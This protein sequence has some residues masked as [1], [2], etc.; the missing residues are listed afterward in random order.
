L[1]YPRIEINIRRLEYNSLHL[2]REM[3]KWGVTVMGVNKVFNGD[4]ECAM[5]MVRGGIKCIAESRVNNLI[6]IR[7]LPCE[8][9]LLRPPALSEI[10]DVVKYA[11]ISLVSDIEVIRALSREAVRQNKVHKIQFTID[12][13][14]IREG[15]WFQERD[16]IDT[17]IKEILKTPNIELHS[18]GTNYNCFGTVM[19]TID[20]G[21][22]LVQIGREIEKK[23]N[24]TIPYFSNGNSTSV[25]LMEKGQWPQGANHLRMG[26]LQ[27]FGLDYVDPY[28]LPGYY[29]S[30]MDPARLVSNLYILKAEIVEC[31]IKPSVPAGE[32]GLDAFMKPKVFKDKGLRKKAVLALGRQD[33]A[34]EEIYP[35][36]NHI[37]ILGQSSDHTILDLTESKKNYRV[38]DR[39]SFEITYTA[40][41]QIMNGDGVRRFYTQD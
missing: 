36:D 31:D 28:Y 12:N 41:M 24:I 23:F 5:A 10:E 37:E 11:D 30:D 8:K 20:N 14:D 2:V 33:V 39:I 18:L 4:L 9:C 40:L 17:S 26:G 7:G 35:I 6:K 38:G 22:R 32:L 29:H 15:I 16:R 1:D 34:Y 3:A 25:V 13:G 21:N 27:E 19:P